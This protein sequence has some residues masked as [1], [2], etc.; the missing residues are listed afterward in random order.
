MHYF[1]FFD[2]VLGLDF[3]TLASGSDSEV[4]ELCLVPFFLDLIFDLVLVSDPDNVSKDDLLDLGLDLGGEKDLE[5]FFTSGFTSVFRGLFLF[6]G[7]GG[8]GFPLA[9]GLSSGADVAKAPVR[10][11]RSAPLEVAPWLLPSVGPTTFPMPKLDLSTVTVFLRDLIPAIS[12]DSDGGRKSIC[13]FCCDELLA[14]LELPSNR[15]LG[16]ISDSLCLGGK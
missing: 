16:E 1:L 6:M 3:L 2:L 8:G 9:M 12:S 13:C 4:D 14:L 10:V 7:G 11:Q 15:S 5:L